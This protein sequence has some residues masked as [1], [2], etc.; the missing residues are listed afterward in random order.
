MKTLV[1]RN[2][3][4]VYKSGAKYGIFD[5]VLVKGVKFVMHAKASER[6]TIGYGVS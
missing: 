6:T 4:G 1:L 2:T 3:F 5:T